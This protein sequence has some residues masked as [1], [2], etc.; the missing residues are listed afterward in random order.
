MYDQFWSEVGLKQRSTHTHWFRKKFFEV[1]M[2]LFRDLPWVMFLLVM[3]WHC[4]LRQICF[5]ACVELCMSFINSVIGMINL[6]LG[7]THAWPF[8]FFIISSVIQLCQHL[9]ATATP[10]CVLALFTQLLFSPRNNTRCLALDIICHHEIV[11]CK[12]LH[13]FLR[14]Q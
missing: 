7:R 3:W 13:F 2:I 5:Q 4:N 1:E 10:G 8:L 9:A 6:K 12:M 14:L 11:S